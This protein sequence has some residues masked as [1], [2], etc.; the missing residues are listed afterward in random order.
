NDSWNRH[1]REKILLCPL[2]VRDAMRIPNLR[3]GGFDWAV[4]CALR[5]DGVGHRGH[6]QSK[7]WEISAVKLR[8]LSKK[9]DEQP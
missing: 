8:L 7:P 2:V 9:K 5:I 6:P 3:V 1:Q 4:Y